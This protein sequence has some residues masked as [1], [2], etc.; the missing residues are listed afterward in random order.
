MKKLVILRGLSGSGKSTHA[1]KHYQNAVLCSADHFFQQKDG[2]YNFNPRQLGI[3]HNTCKDKA[4]KAM[5]HGE[6]I[7]VIDNTNSKIK[8][9]KP[10][11]KMAEEFGYETEVIRLICSKNVAHDRNKHNVPK[12][13]I[14]RMLSRFQDYPG[15]TCINTD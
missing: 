11:L 13:T 7:V 12:E 10:Y 14:E 8:E 4:R 15:E 9:M 6:E 3:A 1:T 5:A 2:S